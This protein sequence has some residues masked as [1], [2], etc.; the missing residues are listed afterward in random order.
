VNQEH[1]RSGD[2]LEGGLT[3]PIG[4]DKPFGL[5]AP[6]T[7]HYHN[8]RLHR[9]L[10]LPPPAAR[11]DSALA[12]DGPIEWRSRLGGLLSDYRRAAIAT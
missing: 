1:V 12:T 7:K 4:D 2:S 6:V 9:S 3:L 5:Q 11:C 10:N 8:E